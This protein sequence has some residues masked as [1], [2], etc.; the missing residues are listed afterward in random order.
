[1]NYFDKKV[2]KYHITVPFF[3]EVVL[4][5]TLVW[6]VLLGV[7]MTLTLRYALETFQEK[8]D[9]TLTSI[10]TSLA[11]ST[12][13]RQALQEGCCAESLI[14]YLDHLAAAT[15]DLE[16]ISIADTNSTRIYHINHDRIGQQFMGGDQGR[17]LAGESYIS[18]AVGTMGYQH[19]AFCP[20]LDHAGNVLGFVMAST[21]QTRLLELR[22]QIYSTYLKLFLLLIL[23]TFLFSGCLAAYLQ[24]TLRGAKPEDLLRN[25]LTQNDVLNSLDEGL[26][27]LDPDGNV[28]LVNQAAVKALGQHEEILLKKSVDDLLRCENGE[29]LRKISGEDLPTNRPNL[30]VNSVHLNSTNRW[31]RQVLILKDKS[32]AFRRAEQLNGTR[33]IVSALRANNHEFM[34]TLQVIS[35]L[36]Q[37]GREHEALEYIGT[38]SVTHAH[39]I[40]P[41]MQLLHNSNVAALILGK[42]DNM[43]ELDIHMTLLANSSLPEHSRYLSTRELVT[44]V[45]NLLENAIEAVNAVSDDR[46]RTIVLQIT[47][48]ENGLLIMLSD[49][50][51]G[52]LPDNLPH[53]CEQ[54]FSTKATEGRGVGMHLIRGIVARHEGSME[55]D[56][57]PGGGTTFTLI[58]NKER[59]GFVP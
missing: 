36:L 42:L 37:M 38:F 39:I 11:G 16:I 3:M 6:F 9:N 2:R 18:D 10:T 21:T 22:N 5:I 12:Y 55:I 29:S 45:G 32:E 31:A 49:S 50:G 41:V 46:A 24:R 59:S 19:R 33:H 25:Y 23:C 47:E 30:L 14:E 48:D 20:V 54:G 43:R 28:R 34:N 52:I 58:F 13:V 27:S 1:M 53:I 40:T 17:V 56:S 4:L 15:S 57:E 8:N 26:I 51:I 7:T 35:G 44:L